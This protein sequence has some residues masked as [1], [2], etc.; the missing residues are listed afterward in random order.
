[1]VELLGR[2]IST[3]DET[4]SKTA[5]LLM[6]CCATDHDVGFLSKSGVGTLVV[7]PLSKGD[8]LMSS[9]PN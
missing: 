7:A 3:Y 6:S 9:V 4:C 1:V 8:S 5:I 2:T